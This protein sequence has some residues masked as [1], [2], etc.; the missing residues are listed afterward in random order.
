MATSEI[1]GPLT[2]GAEFPNLEVDT[3][4]GKLKLHDYFGDKWGI[5]F[6]HPADFTPVCTT[7]LSEVVKLIPDFEKLNVKVIA[8]SC[9]DT[10]SHNGWIKDIQNYGNCAGEFPYPIIAD[11]KRE[12]AVGLGMLDPV[13]KDKTGLPLT[14]RAVFIIGPD[15]KLKLSLL[16]PAT[17]GRNFNEIIRVI[18]S[19][20][21]TMYKKVATPANWTCGGECMVL[22]TVSADDA[23]TLFPKHKVVE[24]PSGKPYMRFTPQP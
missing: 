22:P 11:P 13:E 17:T 2:L 24:L 18:E 23:K 3:S 4:K 6:S 8:L 1:K 10:D 9:N 5:L 21:L 16:Y 20:Q 15:K 14:C 19:L 12:L 7:E